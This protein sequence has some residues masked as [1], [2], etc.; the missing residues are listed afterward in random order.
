MTISTGI[1]RAPLIAALLLFLSATFAHAQVIDDFEQGAFS[2]SGTTFDGSTQTGLLPIHCISST[3]VDRMTI[4][5]SPSTADLALGNVDDQVTTVWGDGGGLLEFE[6]DPAL[7]DLSY[8][9][10][11]NAFRV[12]MPTAVAA[13]QLRVL[14]RDDSGVEES[15]SQS[16]TGPGVYFF[17]YSDYSTADL[18]RV[19]FLRLSLVVPDF[20]DYHVADF[21]AWELAATAADADVT[22]GTVDGPPYPTGAI[23]IAMSG[24]DASGATVPTEIL[25]LSLQNVTNQDPSPSTEMMASDSGGGIGMPGE[26]V[27]IVIIDG[28]SAK[29]AATHYRSIVLRISVMPAGSLTP[30]IAMNPGLYV[31]P[32]PVMPQCFGVRFSSYSMDRAGVA[33][34]RTTHWLG[35]EVPEGSGLSFSHIQIPPVE[36]DA[37]SLDVFFDVDNPMGKSSASTKLASALLTSIHLDFSSFNYSWATGV[38]HWT[39]DPALKV[40]AQPNVMGQTTQLRLSRAL[41]RG[42]TLQ[43]FDL[44]GRAVRTVTVPAGRDFVTWD[45]RDDRGESVASGMYLLRASGS[46]RS[47]AAK[48]VKI[49]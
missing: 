15:T 2:L 21:R 20:G 31:P 48:I 13:G 4:N 36:P 28:S 25:A 6:Y 39:G 33:Q 47:E 12:D 40:W 49:R 3:R 8:G 16:I 35:F 43:L 22:D 23:H 32:E 7:V 1:S 37:V 30:V 24:M 11:L 19:E 34:F 9:G 26:E 5:G 27:G 41:D 29:Q 45:G 38:G 10:N 44:V 17:P 14:V 18:E 42:V 46:V